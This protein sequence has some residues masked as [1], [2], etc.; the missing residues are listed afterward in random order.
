MKY[1]LLLPL[2]LTA[3]DRSPPQDVRIT[4]ADNYA[5]HNPVGRFQAV[6]NPQGPG[7]YVV[8]TK[9]G[10]VHLCMTGQTKG[11][12]TIGIACMPPG[13]ALQTP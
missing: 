1:A 2:A 8:D 11:P 3:C 5:R 9:T 6:P 10:Q 7:V 4:A 12:G 13:P